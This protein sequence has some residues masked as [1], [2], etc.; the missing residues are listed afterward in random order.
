MA[1]S[2]IILSLTEKLLG[3]NTLTYRMVAYTVSLISVI[4]SLDHLAVKIPVLTHLVN[5]LPWASNGLHWVLPMMVTLLA[6]TLFN[7]LNRNWA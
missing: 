1:I 4:S 2:L 6:A 7:K 5:A 3:N